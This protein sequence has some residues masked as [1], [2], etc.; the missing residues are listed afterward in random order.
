MGI[1]SWILVIEKYTYLHHAILAVYLGSYFAVFGALVSAIV[2]FRGVIPASAAAPFI[3]VALEYLRAHFS[4][5]ALPWGLLAHSQYQMPAIIQAAAIAGTYG[6]SFL[7][8]LVNAALATL[9]LFWFERRQLP[10]PKSPAKYSKKSAASFAGS[11]IA[12]VL[13][14]LVYGVFMISRPLEG[15]KI[16]VAVVQ[17]N[18]EQSQK[19]DKKFAP[20]IMRIYTE[21]TMA[22]ALDKPDLI[23]WPE[24]A[25]PKAINTDPKLKAEVRRIAESAGS[26]LLLGSSQVFKFKKN[27][28]QSAKVR[29]SAY[30]VP[31]DPALGI[32]QQ[33]DKIK[34]F[35]FG[36][37]LPYKNKIPWDYIN[38]PDVGNYIPGKEFKV[39]KLADFQF[40]ATICWENLFSDF[41]RQFVKA[42]AQ[43]IV[44]MTNEA[45]FGPSG[46]PHQFVSMNVF[47]AVENRVY[48]IRCTNTGISCFIDP[49]GRIINTVRDENGKAVFVR[50][51][52]SSSIIPQNSRTVYT[53]FGDWFAWFS[54][55]ISISFLL[56]CF[57][58][59]KNSV[60]S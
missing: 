2:R 60:S 10:T 7:I 32:S 36:E 26:P 58:N 49:H 41:V 18:I 20:L 24:T 57:V 16:K 22:A 4:F 53:R 48:V 50:G 5:L 13:L 14:V 42:G 45:W 51:V 54:V 28:P 27:D 38:V 19:W 31:P 55:L 15:R 29:N 33:Y 40:S 52:A 8:V 25:T 1:F 30:L 34:L 11:A 35:P 3:W 46:A 43:F 21:L 9:G 39:F 44:N 6:V 47:R 56:F 17:G 59:V 12:I 23:V 37:Y